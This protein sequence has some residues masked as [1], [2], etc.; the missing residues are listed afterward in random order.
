M[1][2]A[3][4]TEARRAGGGL[5]RERGPGRGEDKSSGPRGGQVAWAE[6]GNRAW[7][8][9]LLSFNSSITVYP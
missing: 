5:S 4:N 7:V 8:V 2:C 9:L 1:E 6:R 3:E